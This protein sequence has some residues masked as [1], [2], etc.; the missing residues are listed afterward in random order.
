MNLLSFVLSL[1]LTLSSAA[2][3]QPSESDENSTWVGA[4]K[5]AYSLI[6]AGEKVSFKFP[7]VCVDEYD[8]SYMDGF[9]HDSAEITKNLVARAKAERDLICDKSKAEMRKRFSDL[10]SALRGKLTIAQR[11][12]DVALKA[13]TQL[14]EAHK[15]EL[16]L[17]YIFEGVGVAVLTGV[18]V[19][20][21]WAN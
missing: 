13:N 12:L 21:I 18:F 14:Q 8:Y 15:K 10:E 3:A 11:D 4:Y 20:A 2:Y 7:M 6:S 17:H 19:Y 16:R 9:I 1:V 5:V